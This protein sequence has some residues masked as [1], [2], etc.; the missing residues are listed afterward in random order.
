M[1]RLISLSVLLLLIL[2]LG[3]TFFR[4]L[5]PLLL[6]LFVAAVMA[7]LFQPLLGYFVERCK[8]RKRLAAGLTTGTIL[9]MILLPLLVGTLVGALQLFVVVTKISDSG[10]LTQ[11]IETIQQNLNTESIAAKIET[12]ISTD[13]PDDEKSDDDKTADDKPSDIASGKDTG[14]PPQTKPLTAEDEKSNQEETAVATEP[15]E[16]A[17]NKPA[18]KPTTEDGENNVAGTTD[19]EKKESRDGL[20]E[21][22]DSEPTD[23]E[24]A[25]KEKEEQQK[26]LITALTKI[27]TPDTTQPDTNTDIDGTS[28]EETKDIS[29][30]IE[31]NVET[32]VKGLVQK[33]WG[34]AGGAAAGAAPRVAFGLLDAIVTGLISS[35]MFVI[36]LY[37]F[38]ADGP[39]LLTAAEGLIPMAVDYQRELLDQFQKV[40]RAVVMATFLAAIAQGITTALVLQFLGFGHFFFFAVVGT[41]ASMIPLA[42]T[43]VVW[44]PC[45]IY[46]LTEEHYGSAIFLILF[47]V[48][49]IGMMDNVIRTYVLQSDVKLHPLLAFVSVMGGLQVMG[50]WGV[51]IGP[52]VASVLHALIQIFNIE[53][54]RYAEER[55]PQMATAATAPD[56]LP[57]GSS[58]VL[59]RSTAE[60]KPAKPNPAKKKPRNKKRK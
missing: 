21:S 16:P 13:E 48:I 31:S 15:E 32:A 3:G 52:M 33:T 40:V 10:K 59:E 18:D 30:Q 56:N 9:S 37:Y 23:E 14:D 46:L 35:L 53:L 4:V 26:E 2:F 20:D 1:A 57:I 24:L 39:A 19:S 44:G 25:E 17:T 12:W 11:A 42:G 50:L 29:T 22:S 6:P 49:V 8:G 34:M 58:K 47:G 5:A 60:E 41:L 27:G 51:F 7:V 36:A 55:T 38:L 28:S 54:K 43:W 45:A